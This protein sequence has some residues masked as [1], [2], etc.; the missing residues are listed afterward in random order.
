MI[1]IT[2]N[3][4][5]AA[6]LHAREDAP[7]ECCGLVNVMHG[8]QIY[9]RCR[10]ISETDTNFVIDTEDWATV[11]DKGEIVMVV[12]SHP[13]TNPQPSPA[14]L[15]HIEKSGLPWL[16]V[17]P[18]TGQYTVN[19]PNGYKAPLVGRAFHHGVLDCLAL[20]RDYYAELGIEIPDYPREN[21]WWMQGKNY[22]RELCGECGFIELP[23]DDIRLHDVILMCMAAP[24]DNHGAIYIG[25]D[26]ILHHVTGRLS[27]R[28]SYGGWWRKVTTGVLRHRS[29]IS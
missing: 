1:T 25:N 6:L 9:H 3:I 22:Y 16:I 15:V 2:P 26:N 4:L 23:A 27:C 10:N 14:D 17:N 20:V 5:N 11:E 28:E 13:I 29:L 19:E 21:N 18:A 7:R 24:V 12:H 8:R